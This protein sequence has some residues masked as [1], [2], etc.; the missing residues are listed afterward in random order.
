VDIKRI[1]ALGQSRLGK[2]VL[3]AGA[4]DPRFAMVVASCSG[5]MGAALSRRDYGETVD[6]MVRAFPYQFCGNFRQ[7]AHHWDN[8]PVDSHM[9][10][11][12]I[13]P[14]PL[15]LNTGSLDRW[16]DPRGEFLA[17]VA[18]GP[19][20]KLLGGEGL[21]TNEMPPLD[22][23]LIHGMIGFQCHTGKHEI[24][25]SDWDKFLDFADLHLKSKN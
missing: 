13:A 1:I 2:T 9:L 21:G 20:Y 14:R 25:V 18:A 16:S 22:T 15:F 10:I 11:S 7:Y 3:W 24:L 4:E 17:A 5:E 19:V 12:L 8:L 23:P 6:D